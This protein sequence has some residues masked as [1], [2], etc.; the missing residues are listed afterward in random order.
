MLFDERSGTPS[1]IATYRALLLDQANRIWAGTAEGVV[2]SVMS[3]PAPLSTK[4]PSL[5]RV[6]V[7]A[8]E[9]DIKS[10]IRFKNEDVVDFY[11]SVNCISRRRKSV[12]IQVLFFWM[13]RRMRLTTFPG[14]SVRAAPG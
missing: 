2:Y 11:F 5:D 13:F 6:Q 7:N 1:K 8:R 3:Y 14:F 10:Q 4:K 12:Q 9:I